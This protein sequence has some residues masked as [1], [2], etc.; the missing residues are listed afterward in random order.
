MSPAAY[1]SGALIEL[2]QK[3]RSLR[4]ERGLTIRALAARMGVVPGTVV[5]LEKGDP[6]ISLGVLSA[7]LGVL[8]GEDTLCRLIGATAKAPQAVLPSPP[9][10]PA[11]PTRRVPSPQ[12]HPVPPPPVRPRPRVAFDPCC[13]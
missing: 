11:S 10:P 5:R 12:P 6:G 2:G 3:L 13:D 4:L 1:H 9:A 7:A 8:G